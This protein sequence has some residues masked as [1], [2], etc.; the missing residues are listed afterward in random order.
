MDSPDNTKSNRPRRTAPENRIADKQL[1]TKHTAAFLKAVA[2]GSAVEGLSKREFVEAAIQ[3]K[4]KS[5]GIKLEEMAGGHM[6][7]TVQISEPGTKG[8]SGKNNMS[9][10]EIKTDDHTASFKISFV[11]AFN[12]VA[13]GKM[14]ASARRYAGLSQR[15]LAKKIRSGQSVISDIE[16]A[17]IVPTVA[18]AAKIV[19][20]LGLELKVEVATPAQSAYEPRED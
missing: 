2:A 10:R 4:L 14:L 6:Q 7:L 5:L 13:F 15:D 17:K 9:Y 11:S 19:A 1:A 3:E 20:G 12:A 8:D 16:N 18:M